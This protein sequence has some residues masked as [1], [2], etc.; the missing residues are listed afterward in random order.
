SFSFNTSHSQAGYWSSG[1]ATGSGRPCIKLMFFS[2]V[3]AGVPDFGT[4]SS[5]AGA[6]AG[7]SVADAGAAD[8]AR[9]RRQTGVSVR[10][11][12]NTASRVNGRMVMDS[13]GG[14]GRGRPGAVRRA[15]CRKS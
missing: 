3:P 12:K 5:G 15:G 7:V 4:A 11:G 6:D 14:G 8:E 13:K 2:G 1:S 10:E 9:H